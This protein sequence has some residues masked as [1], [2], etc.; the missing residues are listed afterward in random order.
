MKL[1]RFSEYSFAFLLL[2]VTSAWGQTAPASSQAGSVRT[3][4]IPL[5]ACE[6]LPCVDMAT[7][8][9]KTLRLLIDT[10]E[11]NSYLDI[12]VARSLGADLRGLAGGG[13]SS[14]A[15]EVQQTTVPGARLGDLPMGDFP[16][17]VFDTKP[18]RDQAGKGSQALP[19]DGVLTFGAFKNRTLQLDFARHL[20]RVSEPLEM[21][22]ACPHECH[23]L[24][25]KRFGRFGPATLTVDGFAV[26]G[27]P[28]DAQIDTLF[29]GTL[30][31]YP[32]AIE[33][34]GLKREAKTKHKEVFLMRQS[35]RK[36]V[37]T[38][39][40]NENFGSIPLLQQAPMYFL[41]TDEPPPAVQFDAKVGLGLLSLAPVT[42]DFKAMHMWMDAPETS[43]TD[44]P[45]AH[46]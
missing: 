18:Q 12:A 1:A 19:A 42:F 28:V 8:S 4:E 3:V 20:M 38:D 26:N 32:T 33:K 30:L 7:G 22:L 14:A 21:P 34:L 27:K 39:S 16:F 10:G 31:V 9:G 29:T 46:H 43:A 44:V 6:G 5:L 40:A 37:R 15:S 13:D 36:L 17:M 11:I 35:E 41:P 24:V 23:D 2:V 25:I 45:A